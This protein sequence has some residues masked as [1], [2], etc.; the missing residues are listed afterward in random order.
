MPATK[1]RE[2]V[3]YIDGGSRG[4]P[5]PAAYAVVVKDSAGNPVATFSK[6]LGQKTNNVAEYQGLL[7]ALDY[8]LGHHHAKARVFSDSELLVRQIQGSYKVK[9]P[10]LKPLHEQARSMIARLES[11]SI[12][13][14]P[15]EQ[16]RE[17]DRLVNRALDDAEVGSSLK[18]A[19][20]STPTV[21]RA[22]AI[23]RR[24]VL[25]LQQPLPLREGEEVDV[26]IRR[27]R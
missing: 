2:I 6:F 16:N 23:H 12:E 11:F 17:A 14:V 3:L 19:A 9:S 27:K 25:N 10:D 26:E 22:T 5:G 1:P 20:S 8:A 21:L 4:N 15:R 24:G 18:P 13:H 7:A